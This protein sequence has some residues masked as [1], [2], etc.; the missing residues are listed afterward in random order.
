MN[1]GSS[2]TSMKVLLIGDN[3]T[4]PNW[5]RGAD[6]ALF[7]LLSE[8]FD[9]A[10]TIPGSYFLLG[11]AGF[12]YVNT[13]TPARY[14]WV[15]LHMLFNRKRRKLFDWYMK[16]EEFWGAKDFINED[17]GKSVDN[18]LRHK[19]RYR[20][21][22]L[23]YDQAENADLIVVNGDGDV[24]FTTPPRR[25]VL[26]LLSMAE[27]GIRLN[28]KVLFINSMISDCPLTGRNLK[29]LASARTVLSKCHAVALRD[30]VSLEYVRKEMPEVNSTY[31]P[32][33]LFA[34]YPSFEKSRSYLPANGDFAIP[35][36]EQNE[37][38]GRLD[39]S[40]PYICVGGTALASKE[41]E[42]LITRYLPLLTEIGK[43]GYEIYL[44]ENDGPDS[45]LREIAITNNFGLIPV[46]TPIFMAGA[47]LANA[48]LFISGRYHPSIFASFG[49]TPCI[50]LESHAHKMSSLQEVLEY[51]DGKQFSAF[52]DES[53]IRE[54]VSTAKKY[55]DQGEVLREKI[56]KVA[57]I[58]CEEAR[59]LPAFIEKNI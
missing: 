17:P 34:L 10:A 15:L 32:D 13:F 47:I 48:Q 36:P 25:Q 29:T 46:R 12:G 28:K 42:R 38:F 16:L 50:F 41:R 5:G 7:Q 4:S 1:R 53:E 22:S 8:R 6:I 40:K 39:F 37:Y 33:S 2:E 14:G 19:K 27:L 52:P 44:T 43:L 57:A 23:I 56:R 35:Y 31:I 59:Q 24:V 58:R 20:E 51:D 26:F 49:G 30:P 11:S 3:R 21:L 54:I 9:V 18:L 45:F 55:L